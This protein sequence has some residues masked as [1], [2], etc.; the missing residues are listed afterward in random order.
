MTGAQ[1]SHLE[2]LATGSREPSEPHLT[3]AETSKEIER[4]LARGPA[5]RRFSPARNAS[6]RRGNARHRPNKE[7]RY[8][9]A[10]TLEAVCGG[11]GLMSVSRP[12]FLAMVYTGSLGSSEVPLIGA[13][14]TVRMLVLGMGQRVAPRWQDAE[15]PMVIDPGLF[16]RL[17]VTA[18]DVAVILA[19]TGYSLYRGLFS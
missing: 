11:A 19:F 14:P 8:K 18:M 7:Q 17:I 15:H 2:T 13:I 4:L 16:R 6:S 9:S 10:V 3:K 5:G 1:A 12:L